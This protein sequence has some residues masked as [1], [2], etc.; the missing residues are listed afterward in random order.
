MQRI[1]IMI[2]PVWTSVAYPLVH[3][4]QKQKI[5]SVKEPSV[6]YTLRSDNRLILTEKQTDF[7]IIPILKYFSL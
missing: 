7:E 3:I 4:Y 1:E 6:N 2:A 5:G